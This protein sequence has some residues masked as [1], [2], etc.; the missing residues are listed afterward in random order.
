MGVHGTG[1]KEYQRDI[2]LNSHEQIVK[3]VG[4]PARQRTNGLHLLGL[5]ELG[6]ELFLISNISYDRF[7]TEHLPIL[8]FSRSRCDQDRDF[9]A[10]FFL[11][12]NRVILD[13]AVF[14]DLFLK[15]LHVTRVSI[16]EIYGV[17]L[18]K[19]SL[20]TIAQEFNPCLV[21]INQ[22]SFSCG[23]EDHI[24]GIIEYPSIF[25]L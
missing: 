22:P 7:I 16:Q 13:K 10:I 2:T 5:K 17:D 18:Q 8:V 6:L 1:L 12:L 21:D 9:G 20:T 19:L 11:V 23:N 3:I 24:F 15:L 25:F 4:Y 14:L